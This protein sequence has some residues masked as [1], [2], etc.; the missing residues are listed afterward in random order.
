M[1]KTTRKTTINLK[2]FF[3]GTTPRTP[4]HSAFL[5]SCG[6]RCWRSRKGD[7]EQEKKENWNRFDWARNVTFKRL[8]NASPSRTWQKP[9][10]QRLQNPFFFSRSTNRRPLSH[11]GRVHDRCRPAVRK[12]LVNELRNRERMQHWDRKC[13]GAFCVTCTWFDAHGRCFRGRLSLCCHGSTETRVPKQHRGL[14]GVRL[15]RRIWG[16]SRISRRSV[17][18]KVRWKRECFVSLVQF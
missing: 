2:N 12:P 14:P 15:E 1:G 7:N 3:R 5:K 18:Q 17:Q 8:V 11:F 13:L 9:T 16:D 4:H 10:S 6:E